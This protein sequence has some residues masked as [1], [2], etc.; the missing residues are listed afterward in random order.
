MATNSVAGLL[1]PV[2]E[3]FSTQAERDEAKRE[4]LQDI[5][6]S[7]ISEF[8]SHPFKVRMDESMAKMVESVQERGVLSPCLHVNPISTQRQNHF[9][10]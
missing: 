9:P 3:L 1:T 4:H 7:A 10:F 8:T 6:L 5:P 2:D